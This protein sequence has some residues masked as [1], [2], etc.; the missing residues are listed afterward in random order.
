MIRHKDMAGG[1]EVSSQFAVIVDFAV[2]YDP[3]AGVLISH[4][5][6]S[7][8]EIDD[9]KPSKAQCD[10]GRVVITAVVRPTMNDACRHLTNAGRRVKTRAKVQNA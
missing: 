10:I 7:R 6:V 5:L 8:C 9:R 1:L 4:R 3:D 2:E